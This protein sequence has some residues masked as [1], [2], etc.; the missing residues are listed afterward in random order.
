MQF[1]IQ[2]PRTVPAR[3]PEGHVPAAPRYG[4]RWDHPVH[5]IVSDYIGVQADDLPSEVQSAFFARARRAFE[6]LDAPDSFELMRCVDELGLTNAVV[7]AYWTNPL[8]HARW[9]RSSSLIAWFK[10]TDRLTDTIGVWRET[11]VVPYDRHETVYSEFY[12]SAGVALTNGATFA[13]ITTNGYFGAARDRLPISAIDTLDSVFAGSFQT[14]KPRRGYGQR[15]RVAVPV[16]TVSLRSGQYW[17]NAV[18]EQLDDYIDNM[19]PRLMRGMEYLVSHRE[20]T[21]TLSLRILTNL[22]EDGSE[23]AQSCVYAHF[24]SL[25]PLERWS[26]D[27][28]TH[29]AIYKHAIAMN[30]HYKEKRQFVSWHELFVLPRAEF[31]YVNCAPK[32]GLLPFFDAVEIKD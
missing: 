20:E 22:N 27:H 12:H 13:H 18:G 16:N 32:T 17:G 3:K 1:D 7:V 14:A 6:E 19:R 29:L 10:H 26:K 25:A 15:L 9:D 23:R 2:Y 31:E 28:A 24:V 5:T 11:A 30:R 21:G 8:R 4:V